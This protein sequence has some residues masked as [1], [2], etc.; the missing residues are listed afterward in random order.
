MIGSDRNSGTPVRIIAAIAPIIH[1]RAARHS[2]AGV[3]L[4]FAI[5]DRTFHS[6]WFRI[7]LVLLIAGATNI[8]IFHHRVQ[9]DIHR[10]DTGVTPPVNARVVAAISL[11]VWFSIIVMGRFIAYNWYDCDIQPQ[12]AFV[13]WFAGCATD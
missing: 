3:L 12:S 10:W 9:R 1:G 6:V 2:S 5:P 4:F 8:W 7:K 13:N 11:S